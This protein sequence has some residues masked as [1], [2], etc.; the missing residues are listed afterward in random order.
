[1]NTAHDSLRG[2][3]PFWLGKMGTDPLDLAKRRLPVRAEG[4][5]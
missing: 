3:S 5:A 4:H 1:M 2:L